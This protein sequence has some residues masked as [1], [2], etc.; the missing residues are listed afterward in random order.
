MSKIL[1]QAGFSLA[2]VY[3][4]RGSKVLIDELRE[5]EGVGL[6][7]EM[8]S[9]IFSERYQQTVSR[10]ASGDQTQS[11]Q[12]SSAFS[13]LPRTPARILSISVFTDAVARLTN[14]SVALSISSGNV[15]EIPLFVWDG[16]NSNV[17][18]MIENGA[19]AAAFDNLV[20]EPGLSTMPSLFPGT[21]QENSIDGIIVR[22][23]SNA[24]GAGNVEVITLIN[25]GT[26]RRKTPSSRGLPI[27]SW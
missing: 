19:A 16:S 17:V 6:V 4:V 26:A 23:L 20:P 1:S 15:R 14:V 5:R 24:F 18:F 25:F 22:G 27:P 8:G 11:V 13:S 21:D 10:N 9:T 7:H 12:F 2:D 3:D